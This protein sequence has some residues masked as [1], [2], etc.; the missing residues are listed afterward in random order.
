MQC[1]FALIFDQIIVMRLGSS[2]VGAWFAS[3]LNLQQ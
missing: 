3:V 2:S 1:V